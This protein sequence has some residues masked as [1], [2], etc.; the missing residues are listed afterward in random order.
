MES[1][2]REDRDVE[3]EEAALEELGDRTSEGKRHPLPFDSD[4]PKRTTRRRPLG[5]GRS[6]PLAEGAT[7]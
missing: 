4:R 3:A 7:V 5:L 2:L 6:L 1:R